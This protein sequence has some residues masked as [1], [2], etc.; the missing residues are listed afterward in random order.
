MHAEIRVAG[1]VQGV[2]FRPFI[3]REAVANKLK[4]YVRNCGDAG[5][6]IV[7]EGKRSDLDRFLEALR[8]RKP[9]LANI[10]EVKV[11]FSQETQKYKT[12]TISESLTK[13][14]V[15]GST[16][17]PDIAICD[18]C[19][20]ELRDA[21]DPRRNYFFITCTNCGP[22][23]TT[24]QNLPYDRANTTMN[25][26]KMC[27]HCR[28]EYSNPSNRRFHAQTVACPRCGPK[29]YLTENDGNPFVCPDPI[30]EAGRLLEAGYILAIKGFGGFHVA[31]SATKDEPALRL[32]QVKHR[33][34]KPFAIIARDLPTIK[35]FAQV[36]E[37][38]K[39]VLSS[40]AR[41]IVLLEKT[42]C[43]QLS[44]LVAPGLH[45]IG[46][47]L[48]YTALHLM[49]FDDTEEPAFIMT[50]ANPPSEPI[51]TDDAEALKKLGST[52]DYFLFHNREIAERCDDSVVRLHGDQVS[53]VRRSRGY[54]PAPINL[55]M[56][57]DR[58]TLGVGAEEN[59]TTCV[60]M[61]DKAFISQYVGDVENLATYQFL[62]DTI[63]KLTMLTN[64]K[65]EAV[66][67]DLH[68]KFASAR[69]AEEISE[70]EGWDLVRIQHHHSHVTS[71]MG[72]HGLT[73]MV[74]IACDGYGYGVDG[75]AWGGEIL[76]CDTD[77]FT[78]LK[79]L[80]EHPL[81]GGDLAARYPL[82][83]V[84][85]ILGG[86]V[87]IEDWLLTK[88]HHFPHGEEEAETV[89]NMASRKDASQTTTSCGRVLDAISAILGIC[90]ERT[91]QGE[92][93]MKLESVATRGR[94]VLKLL[95][96][97][98]RGS[99]QTGNIIATIYEMREKLSQEDLA[100]SAQ[101]YLASGLADLAVEAAQETGIDEIGFSGG[102]AYN[103]SI[104]SIVGKRVAEHGYRFYVHET[105]PAGDGGISFGQAVRS[106]TMGE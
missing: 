11:Y 84:A 24:I 90:Y 17:P 64:A 54:A 18:E 96:Q 8:K 23:F 102:V 10:D 7:V 89:L 106:A 98:E 100:C 70:E 91:Y 1:V 68:P 103:R 71:L 94:D 78:R 65:V 72:E 43:Y 62:Q 2:G 31:A 50:S 30:R 85:G 47:M 95:P 37:N 73:E 44:D 27:S 57:F 104:S 38:E 16:I 36:T 105:I 42:E 82:R 75:A 88:S 58:C 59:V 83:M 25:K 63:H 45:N 80:Q 76:S 66:A 13:R 74:G 56:R 61:G 20:K 79:Q 3:Y 101:T 4:G 29:V 39:R 46:V 9:P 41:P 12:F 81:V 32:R 35:T 93:A 21:N 67:C 87:N 86:I 49:L 14:Q 60:L 52:V 28:G 5:V 77:G 34:Q 53:F 22:R 48:P 55:K 99:L 92:P 69:I 97:I 40:H 6:E 15:S 26:F 19:L 33:S 51:V